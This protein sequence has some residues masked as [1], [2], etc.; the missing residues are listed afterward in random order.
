MQIFYAPAVQPNEIVL[1]ETESKHAITVL[2]LEEGSRIRIVDGCGGSYLCE[3]SEAHPRKCRL[4]VLDSVQN[5]G[6]RA[7]RL[8][9]AIAPT[10]NM[11]RL[12]WFLE[13]ATEIGIDEITPVLC[14]HSERKTIK[15]ERLE[16]ILISAMKQSEK[17]Y[18]PRLNPL[19]SFNVFIRSNRSARKFIAHCHPGGK[20][21]LKNELKNENDTLVVIG[22]EG[23]F[24]ETE[25]EDAKMQEFREISLGSSRLRTETAGIVACLIFH[26]AFE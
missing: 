19:T 8:H 12:E 6:K 11:E 3:I 23:D 16:R 15:P 1:E 4:K 24:S 21:H 5:Y 22:P 13:K 7:Y 25:I 9:I 20:P 10:K 14:E 17:A 2:R 26:L 18:L